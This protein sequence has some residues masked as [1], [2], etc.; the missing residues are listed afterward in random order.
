MVHSVSMACREYF[1]GFHDLSTC[2]NN[3][4]YKNILGV[5]KV[6]SYSTLVVPLFFCLL[7]GIASL[8]S[9]VTATSSESQ[10]AEEK[11]V[12]STGQRALGQQ[13][14]EQ[15]LEELFKS[16]TKA[17]KLFTI[18]GHKVGVSYR[19]EGEPLALG[20]ITV[21]DKVALLSDKDIPEE[22][23]NRI[24]AKMPSGCTQSTVCLGSINGRSIFSFLSLD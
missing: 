11:K 3:D 17:Q 14:I 22:I 12:S 16:R 2:R 10:S 6:V 1:G 4:A 13:S 9:R 24:C 18:D 21:G 20:G 7:Y 23:S 8:I 19:P 15:Q 5:L